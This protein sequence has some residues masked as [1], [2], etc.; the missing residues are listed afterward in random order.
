MGA[1]YEYR[2]AGCSLH[3]E[4]S[5]GPDSGMASEWTTV[6]CN[7][8]KTLSDAT[9]SSKDLEA[10]FQYEEQYEQ[11]SVLLPDDLPCPDCKTPGLR[12][13]QQHT[14]PR[15]GKKKTVL[16][17]G[18]RLKE[19]LVCEPCGTSVRELDSDKIF[20]VYPS[21]KLSVRLYCDNCVTYPLITVHSPG[22]YVPPPDWIKHELK[23]LRCNSR[24]V[25][26]W[27]EEQ[28]C[29]ACGGDVRRS[30]DIAA[31]VD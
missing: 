3:A 9:T 6:W 16:N 29:P 18:N 5:G 17:R 21:D 1:K 11:R 12:T 28:P 20:L 13:F 25:R 24:A 8:C 14:C 31:F 22:S 19:L 30:K 10:E 2:C 27:S 15:C 4:V 7:D 23:C 26:T